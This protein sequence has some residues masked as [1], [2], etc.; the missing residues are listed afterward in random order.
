[1]TMPYRGPSPGL[2]VSVVPE[3]PG[4]AATATAATAPPVPAFL[5]NSRRDILMSCGL[6]WRQSVYRNANKAIPA[7]IMTMTSATETRIS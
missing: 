3:Q 7:R 2:F 4:R 1:M 5:K 6:T